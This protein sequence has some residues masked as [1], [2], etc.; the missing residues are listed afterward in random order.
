MVYQFAADG[1]TTKLPQAPLIW[2]G[3][4]SDSEHVQPHLIREFDPL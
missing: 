2:S 4:L 1:A 3:G